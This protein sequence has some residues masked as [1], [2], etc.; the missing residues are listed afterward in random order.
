M[1]TDI[2]HHK[3]PSPSEDWLHS[4]STSVSTEDWLYSPSASVSQWRQTSLTI[5]VLLPMKTDF[6]HHQ[7]PSPSEDWHHSPSTSVSQWR[8]TS[9]TINLRLHRRLTSLTISFHLPVKTDITHHQLPSPV[10]T[11]FTHHQRVSLVKADINHHQLPSH[12]ENWLHSPSYINGPLSLKTDLHSPPTCESLWR[13]TSLTIIH[14][15]PFL[16]EDW[17]TLTTNVCL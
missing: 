5:N 1:K 9:L 8:L 4:P 12:C 13:L 10:K 11:D 17:L 14:Q 15:C 16:T 3:R 2:T 7:L 6:T